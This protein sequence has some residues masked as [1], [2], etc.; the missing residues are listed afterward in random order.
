MTK[1]FLSLIWVVVA[2]MPTLNAQQ[3]SPGQTTTTQQTSKPKA[4]PP[5]A[6]PQRNIQPTP[7]T[8]ANINP[9]G[10]KRL[11]KTPEK[12]NPADNN[13]GNG[14]PSDNN[15]D[16]GKTTGNNTGHGK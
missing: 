11:A 4:A 7:A 5:R 10:E 6:F 1:I 12:K 8:S 13:R 15:I 14:K 2:A 16:R 9:A 3:A